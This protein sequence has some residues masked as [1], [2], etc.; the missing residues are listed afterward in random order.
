MA[1][2]SRRR[3][4][5]T[6]A[7]AELCDAIGNALG[8]AQARRDAA[9]RAHAEAMAE[10]WLREDGLDAAA[11]DPGLRR[12]LNNPRLRPVVAAVEADRDAAF[13][14]WLEHG[15]ASLRTFPSAT[16]ASCPPA[17]ATS[18]STVPAISRWLAAIL[19]ASK[20][21]SSTPKRT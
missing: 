13:T 19:L 21:T 20:A 15:P 4:R 2:G 12:L 1:L 16:S 6:E 9:V 7:F 17:W 3:R 14:S 10:V 8:A 5:I 18:G 11:E